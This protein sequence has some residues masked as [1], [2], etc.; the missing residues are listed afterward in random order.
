[1]ERLK[2]EKTDG[3]REAFPTDKIIIKSEGK[4]Y[5]D[6]LRSV[7]RNVDIEEA[8]VTIRSLKKTLKGDLLL[9]VTGGKERVTTLK[10]MIRTRTKDTEV[11][12]KSN[13]ATIH[14]TDIDADI[15]EED[16]KKEIMRSERDISEEQLRVIS[17]RPNRTGNQTA[18]VTMRKYIADRLVKKG[19]IKIGWVYCRLRHRVNIARCYKCLEFGHRTPDCTGP[20]RGGTCRRCGKDGHLAKECKGTPY[21]IT[22]EREGHRADSTGCPRFRELI[23]I[24]VNSIRKRGTSITNQI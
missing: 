21:C 18:T 20:D 9:E 10:E 4:T 16:L 19:K 15:N 3:K 17:L 11:F 22:C 12:V 6:L 8:G 1:M 13:D 24:K 14:I 7:K 5:A 2:S 23:R